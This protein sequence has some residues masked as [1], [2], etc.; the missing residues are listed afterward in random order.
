MLPY[1]QV[2][3]DFHTSEAIAGIGK[4]FS[5]ENFIRALKEGHVNSISVFSKCHHGW[6]YHPTKVNQMHPNLDFDLLDAQLSACE[7]AGVRAE[8]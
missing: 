4:R 7:E 6:A 1:R 8:V 3:L 2:H 5:K